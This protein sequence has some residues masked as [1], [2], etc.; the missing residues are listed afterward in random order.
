MSNAFA[1][2]FLSFFLLAL[3]GIA[4]IGVGV[5]IGL[6]IGGRRE[7][8]LAP[9][10]GPIAPAVRMDSSASALVIP[11]AASAAP[12]AT[13]Q[14]S[15]PNTVPPASPTAPRR[16]APAWTIALAIGVMICCC[17]CTLLLAVIASTR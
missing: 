17:C 2:L 15:A 11:V 5:V 16:A 14:T 12:D 10:H 1:V 6:A 8:R 3:V 4:G 7:A 9:D 13:M